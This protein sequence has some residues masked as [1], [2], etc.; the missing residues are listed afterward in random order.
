MTNYKEQFVHTSEIGFLES[1]S[2]AGIAGFVA[3]VLTNPLDIA[4]LRMQV[5]RAE[6]Y[7]AGSPTIHNKFGYKNVF[8]GVFVIAQKEGFY[9]LFKGK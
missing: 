3:S 6:G 8:H 1:T 7:L 9:S 5:Q 2:L 4:K